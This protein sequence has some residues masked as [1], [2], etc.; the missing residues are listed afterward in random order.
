MPM[1]RVHCADELYASFAALS[2]INFVLIPPIRNITDEANAILTQN[3]VYVQ[4]LKN[5]S[6]IDYM[7]GYAGFYWISCI[8]LHFALCCNSINIQ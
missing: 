2:Y 6:T 5:P 1:V 7:N 3:N 4:C 8:S